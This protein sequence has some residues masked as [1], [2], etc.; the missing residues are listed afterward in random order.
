MNWDALWSMEW[1]QTLRDDTWNSAVFHVFLIV[2]ATATVNL[3]ANRILKKLYAKIA[4]R[5]KNPWDDTL[6][7]ALPPPLTLVL[8]TVGLRIA[9]HVAGGDYLQDLPV[10]QFFTLLLITGVAWFFVR[11]IRRIEDAFIELTKHK[12][13]EQQ[14]DETTAHAIGKLLRLSV[15]VTG[16]MVALQTLEIDISAVLAFGGIGGLAVGFAAKDLL[17]NFFGGFMIYLDQ[18]FRVGDWVRSPDRNV[19]G[20]VEYIGWRL[21]RIRTFDKRPLYVPN[22][23]FTTIAI[24]NPQRMLNRR[25]YETIGIRYD[26]VGKMGAITSDV[27]KM[28][29][30]HDEIDQDQL[31][32]VYFNEFGPSSCDFFV[33]TFTKTTVW[34]EFHRVKHDVLLKISSIIAS[35]GA[36]IA[37]PTSTL[38]IASGPPE[39]HK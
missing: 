10:T 21:T 36:E 15:I 35:H 11:W 5:T 26:D 39:R 31:M 23:I 3:V 6:L 22:A 12:P 30:A 8:W 38:H 37:F 16:T 13:D 27:E 18:P 29:R 32:M 34:K 20:T 9:A 14:I 2:F 7:D 24:E 4:A 25:I 17:A 28:L 33:Y 1:L 19:E